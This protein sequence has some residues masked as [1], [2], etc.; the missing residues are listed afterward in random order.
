MK[1]SVKKGKINQKDLY[2]DKLKQSVDLSKSISTI[3]EPG[4]VSFT[5]NVITIIIH[6]NGQGHVTKKKEK[7][8]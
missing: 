1:E 7:Q 5:I 2:Q 4:F 6:S 3:G 8:L